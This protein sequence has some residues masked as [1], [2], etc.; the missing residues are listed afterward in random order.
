M[1][2]GLLEIISELA[3]LFSNE[4]GQ[5]RIFPCYLMCS[6]SHFSD[7]ILGLLHGSAGLGFGFSGTLVGL[8]NFVAQSDSY[9]AKPLDTK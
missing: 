9:D 3:E 7:L 5:P 1:S 2:V 6:V 4:L 8:L